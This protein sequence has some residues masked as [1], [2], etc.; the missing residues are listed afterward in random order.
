MKSKISV[1][2]DVWLDLKICRSHR[3]E[4]LNCKELESI[5]L[6]PSRQLRNKVHENVLPFILERSY[7]IIHKDTCGNN[8]HSHYVQDRC[9]QATIVRSTVVNKINSN[10]SLPTVR[11]SREVQDALGSIQLHSR[12]LGEQNRRQ[13]RFHPERELLAYLQGRT[14]RKVLGV[15]ELRM[16]TVRHID[17]QLRGTVKRRLGIHLHQGDRQA[18]RRGH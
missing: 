17:P 18:T 6:K 13:G 12:R 5:D 15:L 16:H 3:G 4:V 9:V 10:R 14:S 8:I 2:R 7:C 1:L 11:G